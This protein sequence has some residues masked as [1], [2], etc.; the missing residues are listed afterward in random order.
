M[1]AGEF[2]H[3]VSLQ[4]PEYEQ[5]PVTGENKLSWVTVGTVWAKIAALRAREFIAAQAT[6]SEVSTEIF[7][8]FR[9]D[10]VASWRA[11]HMVNGA[12]GAI[13]N[14]AGVMPDKVTGREHLRLVSSAGVNEGE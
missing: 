2:R 14:I 3:R 1:E 5:D 10:V 11:V 9:T 7:I 4:R 12:E 13:Y 8:R 6:Q